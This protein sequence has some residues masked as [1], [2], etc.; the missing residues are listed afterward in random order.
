VSRVAA[1]VPLIHDLVL[2]HMNAQLYGASH[3]RTRASADAVASRVSLLCD[4]AGTDTVTLGVVGSHLAFGKEP[5]LGASMFSKRLISALRRRGTGG[6][7][8]RR[9]V[10]VADVTAVLDALLRRNAEPS[11]ADANADLDAKGAHAVRFLPPYTGTSGA[12]GAPEPE[13]PEEDEPIELHQ[14]AV[15]LLQGITISVCL[16]KDIDLGDVSACVGALIDGLDHDAGGVHAAARYPDFD[17]YTFGHSIRCCLLAIELARACGAD[18]DLVSRV[19]SAALLHDVGK[20]LV[21]FDVLHKKGRLEPEEMAEMRRHPALGAGILLSNRNSDPMHVAAA[22]GHHLCHDGGGYPRTCGEFEQR[23]I[24]QVV[25]ICDVYEALTAVRPY[26]P[27]LEP[28]RAYRV[29]LGMRG[30]FDP[31]LLRTFMRRM[32]MYPSGLRV[33]T[34]GGDV[35]RVLR[36]S[37]D[38]LRPVIEVLS[39]AEGPVEPGER[40]PVDLSAAR[41][42]SLRI[43][44]VAADPLFA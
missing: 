9:G 42:E 44:G 34:A 40:T 32:G 27:P 38:P 43:E 28:E 4:E 12:P 3:A 21:P 31:A 39:D 30:H 35:A 20:A 19:G 24:A 7:E 13:E 23:T 33:R 10:S 26:K 29:M 1:A 5:V 37:A 15:E 41:D 17:S 2:A 6:V 11:V 25:K 36:Q 18:P 14:D 16:G 8:V 22:Y